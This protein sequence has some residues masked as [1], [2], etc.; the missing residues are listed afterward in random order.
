MRGP[1]VANTFFILDFLL[2]LESIESTFYTVNIPQ[3]TRAEGGAGIGRF[4]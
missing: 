4:S 2:F 3:F 1:G